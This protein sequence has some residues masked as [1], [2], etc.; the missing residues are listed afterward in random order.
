MRE[1]KHGSAKASRPA[2]RRTGRSRK[3][4][5]KAFLLDLNRAWRKHGWE[6]LEWLSAKRPTIYFKAIVMLAELQQRRLPEPPGFDRQRYRAD[7]MER[8]QERAANA[9]Q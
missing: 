7:V 3:K 5:G 1:K 9:R 4:L 2:R 8:L 6:T